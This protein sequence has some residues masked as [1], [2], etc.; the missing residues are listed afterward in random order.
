MN[1]LCLY[2]SWWQ[3][4]PYSKNIGGEKTLVNLVNYS[5]SPSVLPIFTISITFPIQMDFNLS[6]FFPPNFLQSLFAKL[7][8][9][10]SFLLYGS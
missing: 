5:I 6:K 3:S 8:Y 2:M 9:R 4:I 7:F 10:Q 1:R